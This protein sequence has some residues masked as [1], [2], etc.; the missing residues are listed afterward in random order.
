MKVAVYCGTRN[1]YFDMVTAVKSLLIHTK[2]DKVYFLIEDDEF[3]YPLP[4]CVECVNASD[5]SYFSF[6]GPNFRNGWTYM[7]L[8]KAAM[9]RI[10][11]RLSKLVMFDVDTIVTKDVSFL[12][13]VDISDYYVAG[14]R[15]VQKKEL[16]INAGVMVLNLD[17]LRDGKG[18]E[19]IHA[20]NTKKYDFPEQECINEL[21]AGK[22][23]AIPSEYNAS[24][25][26]EPTDN[27]KIVHF[28][29][30]SNW[31]YQPLVQKYR[32]MPLPQ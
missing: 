13:N 32:D 1:L 10:F 25:Y 8:L 9:H 3:P 2:V 18:D 24:N 15:E 23:L 17:K 28:A 16:Y 26:S 20:L 30:I 29:A 6:N 11:P 12:W 31:Q 21:C 7:I 27:P 5:Q 19:L 14:V 22:I 4:Q